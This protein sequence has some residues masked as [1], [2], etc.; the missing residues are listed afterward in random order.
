M[1]VGVAK[2]AIFRGCDFRMASQMIQLKTLKFK[3]R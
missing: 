2:I 1:W 3:K